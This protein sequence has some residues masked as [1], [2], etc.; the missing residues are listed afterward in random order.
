MAIHA[1]NVSVSAFGAGVGSRFSDGRGSSRLPA[2]IAPKSNATR[3]R[4]GLLPDTP[5]VRSANKRISA[6]IAKARN[7]RRRQP[8]QD[9]KTPTS[10]SVA[11]GPSTRVFAQFISQTAERP[12]A[13]ELIRGS[14]DLS[15]HSA[16][17]A[18]ARAYRQ[19][20]QFGI[21]LRRRRAQL[22][23]GPKETYTGVR[24]IDLDI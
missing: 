2:P 18:A 24:T 12:E 7:H 1:A 14:G 8:G 23:F 3:A 6:A 5:E 22:V 15:F 21:D 11:A 10:A 20:S 19:T 9:F 16:S 4:T 17:E 13:K